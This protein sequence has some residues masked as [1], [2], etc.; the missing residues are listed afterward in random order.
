MDCLPS[1]HGHTLLP[2]VRISTLGERQLIKKP[3][4]EEALWKGKGTKFESRKQS[5]GKHP[6]YWFCDI[7]EEEW[8]T[9]A[10]D[11]TEG[12]AERPL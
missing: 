6:T 9:A 7:G 2:K 10:F 8:S 3:K 1:S 12:E 4:A 5:E 11:K